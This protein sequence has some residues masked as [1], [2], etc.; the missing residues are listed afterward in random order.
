MYFL[1]SPVKKRNDSIIIVLFVTDPV[2]VHTLPHGNRAPDS[3]LHRKQ[4]PSVCCRGEKG[5]KSPK[6]ASLCV[7]A[8]FDCM[9][10]LIQ[11]PILGQNYFLNHMN[12]YIN[13]HTFLWFS[14]H[15]SCSQWNQC[16]FDCF[17][18]PPRCLSC[19]WGRRARM[20]L[21]S[22]QCYE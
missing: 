3:Y 16:V 14:C 19:C 8:M 4:A 15:W 1:E 20:N 6:C 2:L 7:C 18:S 10:H 5:N 21:F 12:I 17:W 11:L 22:S 13:F 9:S